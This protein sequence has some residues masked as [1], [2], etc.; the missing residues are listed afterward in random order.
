MPEV[1]REAVADVDHGVRPAGLAQ[2]EPFLKTR[3]ERKMFAREASAQRA[4]DVDHVAGPRARTQHGRTLRNFADAEHVQLEFR[5]ARHVA[6]NDRQP[7]FPRE[8]C[9]A[10]VHALKPLERHVPVRHHVDQRP[11][12]LA[13]HRREIA[14]HATDG[15]VPDLLRRGARE[16]V[17]PLDYRIGRQE[18]IPVP[19][20]DGDDGN[21]VAD[22][23]ADI[24]AARQ[25]LRQPPDHL[26]LAE[27]M[28]S[29]H[30]PVPVAGRA[31][32]GFPCGRGQR[33]RLQKSFQCLSKRRFRDALLAHNGRDQLRG[34]DVE[35]GRIHLHLFRRGQLAEPLRHLALFAMLDRDRLS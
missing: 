17:G 23:D 13:A 28:K 29:G 34:R 7:V 32:A 4:R 19:A 10:P 3:L 2:P 9:R 20:F 14:Q 26:A 6:A 31:E 33:P 30:G 21:V 1:R 16:K 12:R 27:L 15:L 5:P 11:Q 8:L 18:E 35:R 24:R 22:P 25:Q